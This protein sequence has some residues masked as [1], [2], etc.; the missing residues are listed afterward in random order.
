MTKIAPTVPVNLEAEN[1]TIGCCLFDTTGD[2]YLT[3]KQ[4]INSSDFYLFANQQ[5]FAGLDHV[6]E[7]HNTVDELLIAEYLN[8]LGTLEEVGGHIGLLS[9]TEN[10][11]SA[12]QASHFADIVR[13]KSK[14]RQTIRACRI[15]TEKAMDEADPA[16]DIVMDL[17]DF[18]SSTEPKSQIQA[19]SE[20]SGDLLNDFELMLKGEYQQNVIRTHIPHLDEK[21]GAGGIAQ[22]EVCVLAA[23]TSCGKS[24]LALNIALR[25]AVNDSVPSLI[26]S[27]EMP[28]KQIVKR[29]VQ[30]ISGAN[31]KQIQDRI[32]KP[33]QMDKVRDAIKSVE[34]LPIFTEHSVKSASD[35]MT[36]TKAMVKRHGIKLVVIDYLQLV[37][38]NS[39]LSKND[40][41]A[42]ISHKVKQLALETN[43]AVLLLCQ[44][45]REGAKRDTGIGLYDL[46][47]SGD[48]ENDADIA[49]L[50]YPKGGDIEDAKKLDNVGCYT[51]L[52][53]IVAKNREGERGV[54]GQFQ[55]RHLSGRFY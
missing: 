9:Y 21:L 32:I 14:L 7:K 25:A 6:Y 40:G 2:T 28:R 54:R 41:I 34:E 10:I 18:V 4:T 44:V 51:Q 55:F 16:D 20:A 52:E 42:E 27:L 19:I 47:D 23:P 15:A 49:V 30:A 39:R 3:V 31:L 29:L 12:L 48:I 1:K 26:F 24:A 5:V 53:Y 36:K 17:A 50:M 13:E 22:G 38:W 35:L 33:D 43:L 11:G 8:G 37:P 46:K 45:N